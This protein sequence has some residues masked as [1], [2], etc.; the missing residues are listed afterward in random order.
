MNKSRFLIFTLSL[1]L[2]AAVLFAAGAVDLS[3]TWKGFAENEG[4]PD[5][6]TVVLEK[7]GDTYTG[8]VT[9]EMGMFPNSSIQNFVVIEDTVT[10]EFEGNYEGTPF[11]LKAEM[12]LDEGTMKGTWTVD[13]LGASGILELTKE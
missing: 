8:T 13:S 4:Y 5:N 7:A 10:F 1:T 6:V 9:D 11:T 12:T 3:G 2:A